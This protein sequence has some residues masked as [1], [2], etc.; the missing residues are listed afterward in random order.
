MSA[1]SSATLRSSSDIK[2]QLNCWIQECNVGLELE[3]NPSLTAKYPGLKVLIRQLTGV[4]VQR[5]TPEIN[6]LV[7]AVARDVKSKYTL[8]TLKDAPILRAYRDFFWRVGIDPTKIRPAAEAL[9]RRVLSGKPLP[10]INTLVDAYNLA[11]IRTSIAIAAFD[12]AKLVGKLLMRS[13]ETSESFLGIGMDSAMQLRGG[14]VVITDDEKLIAVYPYRDAETSKVTET[15]SE[16]ILMMCGCPGIEEASLIQA[17]QVAA[18]L[19]LKFCG[20]K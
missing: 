20:G 3:I 16:L 13:A 17:E 5:T 11:S 15:T 19:V 6:E 4:T 18:E 12:Q 2:P 1:T 9:I 7:E 8:E 10:R 14:E